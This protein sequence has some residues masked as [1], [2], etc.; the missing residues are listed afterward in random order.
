MNGTG[1]LWR[2]LCLI[3]KDFN[4]WI[5]K[6]V[7]AEREVKCGPLTTSH[8]SKKVCIHKG[9]LTYSRRPLACLLLACPAAQ[10]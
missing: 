3:E 2:E 7:A 8:A 10:P 1:F 4:S 9:V 6:P 5:Q